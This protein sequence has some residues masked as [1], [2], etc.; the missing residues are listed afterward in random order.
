MKGKR[1]EQLAV[2]KGGAYAEARESSA[3]RRVEDREV[4]PT[5]TGRIRQITKRTIVRLFALA[6][7]HFVTSGMTYGELAGLDDQKQ[8][9]GWSMDGD[10][11]PHIGESLID[12]KKVVYVLNNGEFIYVE[13]ADIKECLPDEG[14]PQP[15]RKTLELDFSPNPFPAGEAKDGVSFE[16]SGQNKFAVLIGT[17]L[18]VGDL[19]HDGTGGNLRVSN[20]T[21]LDDNSGL[22]TST[23]I[24][25]I[26]RNSEPM[27]LYRLGGVWV[28]SRN[29]QTGEC[30]DIV[31]SD[32]TDTCGE[33]A[34][35]DKDG[36]GYAVSVRDIGGTCKPRK[37]QT[38]T[39]LYSGNTGVDMF[40]A[41]LDSDTYTHSR[42]D[43]FTV[44]V[45]VTDEFG[46]SS[47]RF[48]HTCGNG[49]CT[50]SETFETCPEDCTS[51]PFCG[52]N[53]AETGETC[54]GT[55]LAG[56]MCVTLEYDGGTLACA[57]DCM[58]F[59]EDGCFI[60]GD[61]N[62]DP[63]EI[64]DGLNL[65]NETCITLDYDGGTLS[66][67]IDCQLDPAGCYKCGDG[68][69][70]GPTEQCDSNDLNNTECTDLSFIGGTLS[71]DPDCQFDTSQCIAPPDC[72]NGEIDLGEDC[73]GTNLNG[74]DCVTQNYF[75]GTLSCTACSFDFSGCTDCGDGTC[76]PA[77]GE[78][79]S[80][81]EVDC[82]PP[83][84][85]G[86]GQLDPGEECDP[87]IDANCQ[88]DCICPTP[89]EPNGAGGCEM[90]QPDT[91]EPGP[92]V[93]EPDV[94]EA[95][96]DVVEPAT[97]TADVTEPP[98]DVADTADVTEPPQ[99][100]ADTA[101]T[102]EPPQDVADTADVTEPP[103][104]AADTADTAEPP[105]DA[106]DTA[107]STEPPQDAADTADVTDTTGE[108][109]TPDAID[110]TD[111][112]I[113][114]V[115]TCGDGKFDPKVEQCDES[116][117]EAVIMINTCN[118]ITCTCEDLY[119]YEFGA[120]I[121]GK[122]NGTGGCAADVEKILPKYNL[123]GQRGDCGCDVPGSE[124]PSETPVGGA[125]LLAALGLAAAS[126]KRIERV[127][128]KK[129]KA[130]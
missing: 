77:A 19:A 80:T 10:T 34:H 41:E 124:T 81:C 88:A 32:N 84:P 48:A 71:C 121:P 75:G 8:T 95:P 35:I 112:E 125:V 114:P 22:E 25:V 3:Q 99:D 49:E 15:T 54:D 115:V 109:T 106:V 89:L 61:G 55:D 127:L 117:P 50:A 33:L 104:D 79:T 98:Q 87:G 93:V 113:E 73:D 122:S 40:Y 123:A 62:I 107:D 7:L 11:N 42:A 1:P 26:Y 46:V 13:G 67:T 59:V 36:S 66:C 97:D 108:I 16:V 85:C 44:I 78:N 94:V 45:A 86:N 90:P 12:S 39:S 21:L 2:V 20:I 28:V 6:G 119:N 51:T 91:V 52:N 56:E 111:T 65:D 63:G 82:P 101:D 116:D 102:A 5:V 53:T 68:V 43:K 18:W 110:T 30:C 58:S 9:A 38:E 60:C 129:K 24:T 83:N 72:G 76:D 64:C 27:L 74:E 47:I 17:Q 126:R 37:A 118:G 69:V 4:R 31:F 92:D 105:Q 70:N 130:S 103:Q 57:A 128:S 120:D 29:L 100:A 14:S 23:Q 96:L